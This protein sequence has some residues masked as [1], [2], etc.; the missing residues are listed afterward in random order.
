M[1]EADPYRI[2]IIDDEPMILDILKLYLS[3]G[4]YRVK[5]ASDGIEGLKRIEADCYD[6]IITDLAMPGLTGNQ[7]VEHVKKGKHRHTPVLGI[8][9]MPWLFK[10]S[11]FD[12][13]LCKPYT[14][15]TFLK[16]VADLVGPR[17]PAAETRQP[18]AMIP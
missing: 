5:T 10:D 15:E 6:L 18:T 13:V 7:I 4:D 8:S 9:G 14:M 3:Q 2:L 1:K 12:A 11:P 16:A 17:E